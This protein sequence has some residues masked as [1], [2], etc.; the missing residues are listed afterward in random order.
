MRFAIEKAAMPDADP[1][2]VPVVA[3]CYHPTIGGG[4]YE[5]IVA[6]S[7]GFHV[8]FVFLDKHLIFE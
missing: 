4:N 3:I 1:C 2:T 5:E 7:L 8:A 6:F